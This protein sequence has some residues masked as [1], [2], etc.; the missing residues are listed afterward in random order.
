MTRFAAT[1][2]ALVA[3]LSPT[4]AFYVPGVKSET[5]EKGA[6]IPLKVN[7]MTSIHTQ[8]PKAYYRLPYCEPEGGPQMASENLGEFL[9]GNKVQNSPYVINM[10]IDKYCQKLCQKEL[11]KV[12]TSMLKK[13]IMY[14]YHN[15]WIVDNL[16]SGAIQSYDNEQSQLHYAGGFPI[17]FVDAASGKNKDTYIFNHVNIV[18]DYHE[19][20]GMSEK[21]RV[22]A[23]MVE[24]L[25]VDHQFLGGYDWDGES[26][27]GFV[28]SL[29]TCKTG[30]HMKKKQI[31]K[32]QVVKE[33][34]KILFTYDVI[35]RRSDVAWASR[36]DIYLNEGDRV[37]AQIHWYSIS[38]SLF[39]VVFLTLLVASI[40]IKNLKNDIARYEALL[41]EDEEE[42]DGDTDESGWK[43]VHADVFRPPST[44]PMIY[45]VLLGSGTQL[46]VSSMCAIGLAAIGFI[47]PSK[48]GSML[49]YLLSLYMLCGIL[50]GFTSSRFYKTFQGRAWQ[51]C[52]LLTATL[53]PGTCFTIFIFF[54]TILAF[55]HS[56]GSVPFLDVLIVAAMWCCVSIPLVFI[57][58]YVGFQKDAIEYPCVTSSIARGIPAPQIMLMN[59][60]I[61]ICLAGVIPFGAAYVELFFIMTSLWMDQYYYVFGFTLAVYFILL[62]TSAEVTTL[63]V[64]YQLVGEN[65]RWWWLA[66]FSSGSVSMYIFLYSIVWFQSL[67]PSKL[68]FTYILYFGYMLLFCFTVFIVTSTVGVLSSL[69]F[70]RKMFGS[71]KV[72]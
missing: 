70:V 55:F 27:E 30:I 51:V 53:F 46:L 69:W 52:T 72:D 21:Y 19:P 41:M 58:A 17:G 9:A 4:S 1:L 33:G 64:Y 28:K 25:S 57:G 5:F 22:V 29:E 16:P 50:A 56:T 34:E 48:R 13:H 67:D 66:M 18:L 60:R 43:L 14:G 63:I 44:M 37:P 31:I 20:E 71:I 68:W 23:F 40:L 24:P 8:I 49:N 2:T 15:N 36:W 39:V 11:S 59:P 54:N 3:C 62:V 38:N 42:G 12:D 61:C 65:H 45:C 6:D 26:K 35:W 10:K 47:N 7:S 32:N